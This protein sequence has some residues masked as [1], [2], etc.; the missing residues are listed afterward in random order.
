MTSEKRS[1]MRMGYWYTSSLNL[2]ASTTQRPPS[3][4]PRQRGENGPTKSEVTSE[5]KNEKR[6]CTGY[7]EQGQGETTKRGDHKHTRETNKPDQDDQDGKRDYFIAGHNV[8]ET[9]R[10]SNKSGDEEAEKGRVARS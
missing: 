1:G 4:G 5:R 7:I 9:R 8:T 2:P 3:G 6:R 10:A